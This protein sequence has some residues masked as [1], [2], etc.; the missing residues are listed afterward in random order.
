MEGQIEQTSYSKFQSR[1]WILAVVWTAILVLAL[2][3]YVVVALLAPTGTVNI[4]IEG[5][6][7]ATLIIVSWFCGKSLTK[8]IKRQMP[9]GFLDLLDNQ[10]E[11]SVSEIATHTKT[12]PDDGKGA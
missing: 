12:D 3:A 4:P 1:T 2:G 6:L 9:V 10:E 11:T 8:E 5:I 7:F